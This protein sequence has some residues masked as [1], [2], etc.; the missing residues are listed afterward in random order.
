MAR[1]SGF[2][3]PTL[4]YYEKIGLLGV[5]ERD[6]SSGHRRYDET[7]VARVEALACLRSSGV[8]V[9]GMRRYVEL[10]DKGDGAAGELR[11]LFDEHAAHLAAEIER[12]RVRQEY[13]V[14][15]ARMWDARDQGDRRAEAETVKRVEE[16]LRRF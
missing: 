6:A 13:L 1:R 2:S 12:L 11:E 8:T 5:V 15:K 16:I 10:V 7:V 9:D 3:E 14:L 4:R